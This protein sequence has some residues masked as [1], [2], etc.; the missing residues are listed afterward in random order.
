MA[1]TRRING[2]WVVCGL[3]SEQCSKAIGG[4]MVTKKTRIDYVGI[5][6]AD[7]ENHG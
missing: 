4:S 2:L 7:F 3:Y 1:E 5:K 6:N